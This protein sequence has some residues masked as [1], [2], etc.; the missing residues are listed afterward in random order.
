MSP[1]YELVLRLTA[2]ISG[3]REAHDHHGWHVAN[4]ARQLA[5]AAGLSEPEVALIEVGAHLHD[6]GKVLIR[7]EL[8]NVPRKLTETERVEVL[9]GVGAGDVLIVGSAKGV[10]AGTPVKVI[11]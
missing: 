7:R 3:M 11:G 1:D 6:I 10:A 2:A 9:T 4:L 8:L 5:T